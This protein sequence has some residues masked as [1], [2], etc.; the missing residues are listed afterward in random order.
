MTIIRYIILLLF[1]VLIN[2]LVYT[3]YYY[4]HVIIFAHLLKS[5]LEYSTDN[6]WALVHTKHHS[7]C[8]ELHIIIFLADTRPYNRTITLEEALKQRLLQRIDDS[9]RLQNLSLLIKYIAIYFSLSY[10]IKVLSFH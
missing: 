6:Y 10:S 9:Y 7:L 4:F 8:I 1:Y 5:T 3:L 2:L